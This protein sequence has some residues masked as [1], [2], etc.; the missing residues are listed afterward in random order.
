MV[1]ITLRNQPSW[2]VA[3]TLPPFCTDVGARPIMMLAAQ[4][5]PFWVP[6]W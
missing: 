6:P 5:Q 4:I 1:R 3:R 2:E